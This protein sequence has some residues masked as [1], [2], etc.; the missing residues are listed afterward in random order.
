MWIH[1]RP[2]ELELAESKTIIANHLPKKEY[3]KCQQTE[4]T[5][6]K[7]S[8][9]IY[10]YIIIYIYIDIHICILIHRTIYSVSMLYFQIFPVSAIYATDPRRKISQQEA[11]QLH[12]PRRSRRPAMF[13]GARKRRRRPWTVKA[14]ATKCGSWKKHGWLADVGWLAYGRW[15][16][17]MKCSSLGGPSSCLWWKTR[18][19]F[20]TDR[21]AKSFSR[22]FLLLL[23][24][25]IAC[26]SF[27]PL[28]F[29]FILRRILVH[30]VV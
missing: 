17:S 4:R 1:Q 10:K 15:L 6:I 12:L 11:F 9:Y 23:P 27:L 29:M 28:G 19:N 2:E 13:F 16:K 3:P 25:L 20:G 26:P 24:N 21:P 7:N 30:L 18:K 14:A 22:W 5:F 8:M